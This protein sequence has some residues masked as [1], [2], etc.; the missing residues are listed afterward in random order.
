MTYEPYMSWE[1][2][3][4]GRRGRVIVRNDSDGNERMSQ[5]EEAHAIAS[6][7]DC[8]AP[9]FRTGQITYPKLATRRQQLA[10]SEP[11]LF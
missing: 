5:V 9:S 6:E 2:E 3:L 4:C 1:C 8:P 7:G 11:G 10:S